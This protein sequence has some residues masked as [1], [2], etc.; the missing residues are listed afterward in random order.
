MVRRGPIYRPP[1]GIQKDRPLSEREKQV[2]ELASYGNTN[3]EIA[4]RL[5]I[6]E[7]TVK[8]HFQR[9]FRLLEVRDRAAAVAKALRKGLIE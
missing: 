2:L 7:D 4:K 9:A 6:S 3:N 1:R 5:F 8:T